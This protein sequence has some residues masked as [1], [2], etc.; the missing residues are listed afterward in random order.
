MCLYL[1]LDQRVQ[2]RMHNELKV[3]NF[4]KCMARHAWLQKITFK[5]KF[6]QDYAKNNGLLDTAIGQF[7]DEDLR[8]DAICSAISLEHRPK[9]IY[10][11]AVVNVI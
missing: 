2:S 9:L 7:D 1:T 11:N 6:F 8:L 3:Y 10:T 5:K 4:Y